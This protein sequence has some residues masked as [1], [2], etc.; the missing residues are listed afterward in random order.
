MCVHCA[1]D[2]IENQLELHNLCVF[3][4]LVIQHTKFMHHI[5]ICVLPR[6]T[7][8]P[9]YIINGTISK[10]GYWTQNV[11]FDFRYVCVK[12]FLFSEEISE[13]W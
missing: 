13:M 2:A 5:T 11:C 3:V 4:S 9:H 1:I 8:F 10:K 12:H 7:A 6:S